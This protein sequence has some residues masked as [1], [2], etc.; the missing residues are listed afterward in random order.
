MPTNTTS[1]LAALLG[2]TDPAKESEGQ[3]SQ[4]SSGAAADTPTPGPAVAESQPSA[5]PPNTTAAATPSVTQTIPSEE[6]LQK[7]V[8]EEGY[9]LDSDDPNLEEIPDPE[10]EEEDVVTKRPE[11]YAMYKHTTIKEFKVGEFRFKKGILKIM[12][13]AENDR[14][15]SYHGGLHPSDR[16]AIKKLR[17]IENELAITPRRAVRGALGTNKIVAPTAEYG[18]Q[19]RMKV[20]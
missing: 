16:Q 4:D 2:A 13:P 6:D 9:A 20:R 17:V 11:P 3:T 7:A 15:L 8:A 5:E 12:T 19:D 1:N 10:F 14:F 18:T